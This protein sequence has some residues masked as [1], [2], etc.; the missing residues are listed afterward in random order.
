MT[1]QQAIE[2]A[3]KNWGWEKRDATLASNRWS[4]MGAEIIRRIEAEDG[5][6]VLACT[7]EETVGAEMHYLACQPQ[8]ADVEPLSLMERIAMFA[9]AAAAVTAIAFQY[10]L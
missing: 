9:G 2:Y 4:L 10:S 5:A 1:K 3:T 8:E 6:E 7:F